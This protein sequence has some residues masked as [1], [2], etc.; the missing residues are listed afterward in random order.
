MDHVTVPEDTKLNVLAVYLRTV[1]AFQVR[2]HQTIVILLDFHVESADTFIVQLNRVTLFPTDGDWCFQTIEYSAPIGTI[3]NA[4]SNQRHGSS[5][6]LRLHGKEKEDI[7]PMMR[8]YHPEEPRVKMQRPN[9]RKTFGLGAE[10]HAHRKFRILHI[11]QR[12]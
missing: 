10:L 9:S 7:P 11:R 1:G 2:Q 12:P 5:P 6:D 3:E 4:Q 8:L